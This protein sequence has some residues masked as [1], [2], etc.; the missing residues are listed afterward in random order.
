MVAGFRP[1]PDQEWRLH[2]AHVAPRAVRRDDFKNG[3]LA[4]ENGFRHG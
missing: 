1:A 4:W 3:M 2:H